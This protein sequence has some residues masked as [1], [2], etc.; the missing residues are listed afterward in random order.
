MYAKKTIVFSDLSESGIPSNAIREVSLLKELDH[1]NLVKIQEVIYSRPKLYLFMDYMESDLRKYIKTNS[2][3]SP[4]IIQGI[5]RQILEGV[6]S[7]HSSRVIHRDLKPENIFID[8]N[9]HIK[10]GDFG[11]S[12]TLSVSSAPMSPGMV[13]IYYRAPEIALGVEEYSIPI[14]IWS[15]GCIFA[16]LFLGSPLFEVENEIDLLT[17]IFKAVGAPTEETWPG[18]TS[19]VSSVMP[20]YPEKQIQITGMDETAVDLL[21][22][23]FIL[24]PSD[25]ISAKDALHHPYFQTEFK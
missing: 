8:S 12:R 3:I 13:T 22:K 6:C 16:E 17:K 20:K 25:R 10:I 2:P 18:I 21:S 23:M 14:D 15:I 1:Q 5:I 4:K 24:Y 7:M 9:E 11:I 19:M